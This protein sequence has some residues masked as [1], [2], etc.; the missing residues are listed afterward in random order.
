MTEGAG[1]T[2][3]APRARPR[4][5]LLLP[6]AVFGALALVFLIRLEEGGDPG[7]VPSVLI[8]HPAPDFALPPLDGTNVPG[9]QRADLGGRVTVVNVFASWCVP[10]RDEHPLLVGL[11]KDPRVHIVGIDYKDTPDNARR[12]LGDL[13]NPYAAIGVDVRGRSTIDWGVYGVPETFLVGPDGIIREKII[14]PLTAE[15]I[16]QRLMPAVEKLGKTAG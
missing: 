10:C 3:A 8:G 11:A 16:T 6:V 12:F 13:G 1:G 5:L 15:S 9:L 7:S 2:P 14:G 4:A